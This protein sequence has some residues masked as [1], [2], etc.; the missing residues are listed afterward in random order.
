MNNL[1]ES[2]CV[3]KTGRLNEIFDNNKNISIWKRKLSDELSSICKYFYEKNPD[4]AFSK[5]INIDSFKKNLNSEFETDKNISVL[6]ND[7]YEVVKEFCNIFNTKKVWLRLDSIDKPM[8]P[9]FHTDD[10]KCRMVT[11]YLG[12]GTQW[13]PKHLIDKNMTKSDIM[14]LNVGD[15]AL[16]K[17]EG[18]KGNEENGLI[19]RSPH[20]NTNYKRLYMTVDFVDFYYKLNINR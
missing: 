2:S 7:I 4:L 12:P 13:I 14:Q 3:Q 17:G 1:I 11:T 8:C 6:I 18:W 15:V 16:L 9:N 19:H 5:I 10:V 20:L